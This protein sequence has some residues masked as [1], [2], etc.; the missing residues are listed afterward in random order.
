MCGRR[1]GASEDFLGERAQQQGKSSS[2]PETIGL[3][4]TCQM[5]CGSWKGFWHQASEGASDLLP[6]T[7]K[8]W[9]SSLVT[10]GQGEAR[11]FREKSV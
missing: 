2:H 10:K 11:R 6:E 4:V 3:E 8:A 7:F 5:D 9:N 1:P